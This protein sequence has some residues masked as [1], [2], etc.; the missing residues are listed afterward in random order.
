MKVVLKNF[1][2]DLV[3]HIFVN[4]YII[5]NKINKK[6]EGFFYR[7]FN[8]HNFHTI[9]LKNAQTIKKSKNI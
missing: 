4:A 2:Y 6:N 5:I 1:Q 7:I 8:V 3:Y 9:F